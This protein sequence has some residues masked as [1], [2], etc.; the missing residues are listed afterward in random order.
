MHLN[1]V[2]LGAGLFPPDEALRLGLVDELADNPEAAARQRLAE[3]GAHPP[4]AYAL[5]KASLRSDLTLEP[6][7]ED[8]AALERSAP[9]WTSPSLRERVAKLLA[10]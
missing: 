10:R 5:A 8:R 2:V 9:L 3:L 4:E 7:E 6:S 1:K